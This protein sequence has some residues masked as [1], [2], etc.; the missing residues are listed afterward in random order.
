M[1]IL[2]NRLHGILDGYMSAKACRK[3]LEGNKDVACLWRG[4]LLDLGEQK[5]CM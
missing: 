1:L 4:Q 5:I 2:N 3:G